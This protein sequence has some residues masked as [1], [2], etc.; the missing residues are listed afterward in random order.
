MFS[1]TTMTPDHPRW[2]ELIARLEQVERCARTT[3]NARAIMESMGGIDVAASLEA[4][5][6]LGGLCDCSILY[7]VA[8]AHLASA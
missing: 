5:R 2:S 8:G 7:D 3:A 4:L 6:R 1:F